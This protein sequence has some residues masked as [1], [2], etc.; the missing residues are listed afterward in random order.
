MED[1]DPGYLGEC[2]LGD[3]GEHD[4]LS[5]CWIRILFVFI[6]PSLESGGGF[7]GR[8]FPPGCQ[9]SVSPVT[10]QYVISIAIIVII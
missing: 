2:H 4:L 1:I 8:I 10:K 6:E 7:S 9:V 5:F 3:D